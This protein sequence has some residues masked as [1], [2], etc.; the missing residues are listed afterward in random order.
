MPY[1][2][3]D[4][5][6]AYMRNYQEKRKKAKEARDRVV[7]ELQEIKKSNLPEIEKARKAVELLGTLEPDKAKEGYKMEYETVEPLGQTALSS[8][9]VPKPTAKY[10]IS[11]THQRKKE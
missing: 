6:L 2:K 1:K 5:Q 8:P 11:L 9:E 3:R 7:R 4:K 10:V